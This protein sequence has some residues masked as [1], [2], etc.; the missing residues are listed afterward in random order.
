MVCKRFREKI[1][2]LTCK[3]CFTFW[4]GTEVMWQRLCFPIG[5]TYLLE[6]SLQILVFIFQEYSDLYSSGNLLCLQIFLLANSPSLLEP[7]GCECSMKQNHFFV[8]LTV[9]VKIPRNTHSSWRD[10]GNQVLDNQEEQQEEERETNCMREPGACLRQA[11]KLMRTNLSWIGNHGGCLWTLI[12]DN[13]KG[14]NPVHPG[15]AT[16][17]KIQQL[18][19]EKLR[20]IQ[21]RSPGCGTEEWGPQLVRNRGRRYGRRWVKNEEICQYSCQEEVN[22][23]WELSETGKSRAAQ[24]SKVTLESWQ[25]LCGFRLK[26]YK[27]TSTTY[28]SLWGWSRKLCNSELSFGVLI[29]PQ[30]KKRVLKVQMGCRV[31]LV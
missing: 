30:T 16:Y 28:T 8:Q 3:M 29:K 15:K 4:V 27:T 22:H 5:R 20:H 2:P 9:L 13:C 10:T 1:L 11:L 26:A 25:D 31:L 24:N 12:P 6:L 21:G 7:K 19:F 23:R 14:E 17:K 18:G